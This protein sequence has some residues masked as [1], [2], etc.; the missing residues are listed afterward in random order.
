MQNMWAFGFCELFECAHLNFTISGRS[1]HVY[2][3]ACAQ[4][5]PAAVGLTQA[6]PNKGINPLHAE[7]IYTSLFIDLE[8]ICAIMSQSHKPHPSQRE[9]GSG[10]AAT[11]EECHI[12]QCG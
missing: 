6:C 4:C 8:I 2:I 12:E 3:H 1:K 10:F 9:E 5:S 7:V 11:D